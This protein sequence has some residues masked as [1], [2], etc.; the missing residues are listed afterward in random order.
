MAHLTADRTQV[1]A[2][3]VFWGISGAGVS[4]NLRVIHDKL[5]ADHRG[6]LKAVPTRLDPTTSYEILPIELGQVNGLRT[7]LQIVGVPCGEEHAPT[8]KQL[9]DRIDGLVLVIDSRPDKV[10][11]NVESLEELRTALEAYGRTLQELPIV[12]QY[13]KRDASDPYVIEELHRRLDLPGAAVFEASASSG[14]GVLQT[15]TTI[16]KRVIRV[17]RESNLT[18][19]QPEPEPIPAPEP[20]PKQTPEPLSADVDLMEDAILAEGADD[21]ASAEAFS[22]AEETLGAAQQAL[23]RPWDSMSEELKSGRG[24][25]IGSDFEIVSVGQARVASDRSIQLPVVLGNPEGE[26]VTLRLT[27]ALDPLLDH[28]EE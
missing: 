14:K 24:A 11:A 25:R 28:E 18:P 8:R 21:A 16:S 17:L 23:D 7:Q 4:T 19:Q 1:N 9:L 5:R 13:N 27:V 2:R 20:A 6:E 15:L 10:E 3:I 22:A 12:V 26:T